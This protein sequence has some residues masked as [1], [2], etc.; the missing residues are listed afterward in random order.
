[1]P[2]SCG[3]HARI[4][5]TLLRPRRFI[6]ALSSVRA[7]PRLDLTPPLR[8]EAIP[9]R[10]LTLVPL[11]R[12]QEFRGRAIIVPAPCESVRAPI[13]RNDKG[14]QPAPTVPASPAT[15]ARDYHP[16]RQLL[17]PPHHPRVLFLLQEGNALPTGAKDANDRGV[18]FV[19]LHVEPAEFL[20]R[21]ANEFQ[22]DYE[23]S[24]IP[25]SNLIG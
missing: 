21:L 12:R 2:S 13:P 20:E 15:T 24:Q 5:A 25:G 14:K 6:T 9:S 11:G 3:V 16:P 17:A 1:V 7:A 23:E 18:R 22:I 8:V 4:H 19:N 10:L